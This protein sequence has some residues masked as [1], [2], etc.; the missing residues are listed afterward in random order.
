MEVPQPVQK[1]LTEF[2]YL[3]DVPHSL[4]PR[5]AIDHKITPIPGA[6]PV[7]IRPYWYSPQQKSEI[8]NQVN[9]MLQ[10]GVIQMSSSPFASSVL[11]VKKKDGSWHFCVDYRALNALIVKNKHPLP[12]VE[13][14][15]DELC[16]AQWFT[17][18]DL[19]S[20]YH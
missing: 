9:E 1:L 10:S 3:F 5:R 17:K 20:G 4:P 13:K 19:W 7:N 8:E 14:L 2:Q 15:L 6:Q 16:G 12:V 18:L 11:L